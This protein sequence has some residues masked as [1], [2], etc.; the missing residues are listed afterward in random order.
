M[1]ENLTDK[2]QALKECVKPLLTPPPGLGE[3][4]PEFKK[5]S[6]KMAQVEKKLP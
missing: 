2:V 1:L 4:E 3:G 5:Q 6:F